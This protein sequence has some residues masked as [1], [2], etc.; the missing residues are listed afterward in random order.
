MYVA[1]II[2]ACFLMLTL[3]GCA[4]FRETA[5]KEEAVVKPAAT[6]EKKVEAPKAAPA[7]AVKKVDEKALAEE[8]A[9]REKLMAEATAFEDVYFEF[10]RYDLKPSAR[11]KLDKLSAWLQKNEDF[12]I[13]VEG[14]C[15]ERG[16]L[17]YNL[18]LGERRAQA[19]KDYLVNLGVDPARIN[20]ISYGEEMPVDPAHNEEAWARNRRDHFIVFPTTWEK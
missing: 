10:D 12:N 19:A 13:N 11:T 2:S 17:E 3:G 8:K 4:C 5:V 15:D 20:T 7:P 18:A 16:T 9:R 1:V 6:P 14:H